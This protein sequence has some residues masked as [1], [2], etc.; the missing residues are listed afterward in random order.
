MPPCAT[1]PQSRP[2]ARS[3]SGAAASRFE[4]LRSGLRRIVRMGVRWTA[5]SFL[6]S[7]LIGLKSKPLSGG[8]TA[9]D[10]RRG[11]SWGCRPTN[12][13]ADE[14]KS[15]DLLFTTGKIG[16]DTQGAHLC[17]SLIN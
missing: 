1:V 16:P 10:C 2:V 14:A 8:E 3:V 6:S 9:T 17:S 5:L 4:R 7:L 12:T 15:S 13:N 11:R